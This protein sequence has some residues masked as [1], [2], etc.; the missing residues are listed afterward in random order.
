MPMS[1]CRDMNRCLSTHSLDVVE[2]LSVA[3]NQRKTTVG[4]IAMTLTPIRM[5][6]KNIIAT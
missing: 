4:Y 2:A 3:G 6:C 5:G 1:L